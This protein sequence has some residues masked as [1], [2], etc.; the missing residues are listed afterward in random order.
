[1]VVLE[2]EINTP[3]LISSIA[4]KRSPIGES[5][6]SFQNLKVYMGTTDLNQLTLNYMGNYDAAGRTLV[7]SAN[8]YP[9]MAVSDQWFTVNLDT[10]YWFNGDDNLII[11]F[12]WSDGEGSIY[13]WHWTAGTQRAVFG[14]YGDTTGSDFETSI[15]HLQLNGT[16][17]LEPSTFASIKTGFGQE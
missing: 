10:P 7:L 9:V 1:V 16:L 15:P 2:S 11:E 8:P 6:A 12:E 4:L 17:A 13:A 3:M 14:N 5:S